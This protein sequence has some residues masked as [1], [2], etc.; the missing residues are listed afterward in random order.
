LQPLFQGSLAWSHKFVWNEER[1]ACGSLS[2]L[3]GTVGLFYI[4]LLLLSLVL[5]TLVRPE[6]FDEPFAHGRAAQAMFQFLWP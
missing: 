6:S 4:G 5:V 3:I 1:D 2:E